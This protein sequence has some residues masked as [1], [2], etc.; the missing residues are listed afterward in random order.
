MTIS[1]TIRDNQAVLQID[2]RVDTNTSP[3]LQSAILSAFQK[4]TYIV[5]DFAKVP[6]ISS[7]GLRSLLLGQKTANSKHATMELIHV[8]PAVM[9]VL[10]AVGF[11]DILTI[12]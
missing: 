1:S 9:Q 3:Q 6:Y 7:A 10:Q 11:A 12:H 5:L 4:S 8:C 2:G